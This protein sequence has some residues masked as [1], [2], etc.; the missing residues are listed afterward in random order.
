[1]D[2]KVIKETNDAF[3]SAKNDLRNVCINYLCEALDKTPYFDLKDCTHPFKLCGASFFAMS[4]YV[5]DND[6]IVGFCN[7]IK[8][9]L[10]ELEADDLFFLCDYINDLIS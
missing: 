8:R 6:V 10:T 1:M 7:T 5:E 3:L 9:P 2:F 4:I